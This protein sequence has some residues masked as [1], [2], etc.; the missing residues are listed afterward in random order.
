MTL[1]RLVATAAVLAAVATVLAELTPAV[2]DPALAVGDPQAFVDT[3]GADTVVAAVAAALAWLVWGWGALGV[4]L[5]ALSAAPGAVGAV[6]RA[7]GRLLVP[8]AVRSTAAAALGVGL[9]V[10][11]PALTACAPAG[12]RPA[13][14]AA[15]TVASP[16]HAAPVPDWP[17]AQAT[18]EPAT[19]PEPTT[20]PE[21]TVPPDP[22]VPPSTGA[23]AVPDTAAPDAA[24]AGPVPDWPAAGEHVVV[25]GDSLW[26]IAA[27]DLRA[28]SGREPDAAE[29]ARAVEA[30]WSAN[31]DVVGPDPDLLLPG[32]VLRAPASPHPPTG[33]ESP[34]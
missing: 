4:L 7:L 18:P 29:V 16:A 22:T 6:A 19:P 17:A 13:T 25:R 3:A 34:E 27:A 12:E 10:G 1:R 26:R 2:P 8:A 30:W 23:D 31:A 15:A 33:S 32:Q 28:R 20:P 5:T 21:A 11:A 9:V 24:P 14:V